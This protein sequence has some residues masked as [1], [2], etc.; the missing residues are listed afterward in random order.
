MLQVL[1]QTLIEHEGI[2]QI[3]NH[4]L[5]GERLQDVIHQPH[6]ISRGIFQ[7][8]GHDQPLKKALLGFE[9]GLPYIY[10]LYWNL[11][12]SGIQI[13][14]FEVLGPLELVKKVINSWDWVPIPDRGLGTCS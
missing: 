13:K 2:I 3:Y 12:I 8:K 14:F 7:S 11:V 10:D 1:Y 6:K 4:K 5:V 9:G